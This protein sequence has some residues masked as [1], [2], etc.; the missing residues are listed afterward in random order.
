MVRGFR[1]GSLRRLPLVALLAW[2]GLA[3][4]ADGTTSA[5]SVSAEVDQLVKDG[6]DLRKASESAQALVR[7]RRAAEL[8]KSARTLG[9][10]GLVEAELKQWAEAEGHLNASLAS[11]D[12]EWL[13]QHRQMLKGE[14]PAV[15][16]HVGDLVIIGPVGAS[17][18]VNGRPVGVLPLMKPVRVSEGQVVVTGRGE[19]GDLRPR[20]AT[21]SAGGTA[22]VELVVLKA[23]DRGSTGAAEAS[24]PRVGASAETDASK[25]KGDAV[26]AEIEELGEKAYSL[27][28][29]RPSRNL[30]AYDLLRRAYELRSK[31][32]TLALLG[33]VEH[34]LH[35]LEAAESHLV[36]SF[37]APDPDHWHDGLVTE[38]LWEGAKATHKP[39]VLVKSKKGGRPK[40]WYMEQ[41][42]A[43]IRRQLAPRRKGL[44]PDLEAWSY[45]GWDLR[46]EKNPAAELDAFQRAFDLE[47]S[48]RTIAQMAIAKSDVGS[49]AESAELLA[50]ARA[51]A[52]DPWVT[53]WKEELDEVEARNQRHLTPALPDRR[54]LPGDPPKFTGVATNGLPALPPGQHWVEAERIDE[55]SEARAFWT[56]PR[57]LGAM[58]AGTG[59]LVAANGVRLLVRGG[60]GGCAEEGPAGFECLRY[61]PTQ[62]TTP[63]KLWLGAGLLTAAVGTALLVFYPAADAHVALIGPGNFALGGTW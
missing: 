56:G 37:V 59:A 14:L 3:A 35:R 51:A 33:A 26:D 17:V 23:S 19:R 39:L 34:A 12:S 9:H 7:F 28:T 57:I 50:K 58:A 60:G 47:A 48:P 1:V 24:E 41:T 31:A 4:A 55:P 21:V 46:K 29:E 63:G 45:R 40:R 54:S 52:E 25:T 22:S 36:A 38:A 32:L 18:A 43:D 30:E 5:P 49:Y 20:N 10:L 2:S 62:S 13:R 15:S 42:L 6:L 27:R 53:K 44:N 11:V 8:E 16:R 61:N